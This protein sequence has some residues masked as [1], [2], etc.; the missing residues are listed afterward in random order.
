MHQQ[1]LELGDET[2]TTLASA[3][4]QAR[5]DLDRFR[6]DWH[7]PQLAQAP[8]DVH[9]QAAEQWNVTGTPTILF[10]NGRPFHLEF[11]EAPL[12]VAALEMFRMIES[13]TVSQPYIKQL[14]QTA[15][16]N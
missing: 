9:A 10:P 1:Y 11:S 7:D 2:E 6:A 5:L 14:L 8:H 13:L 16:S 3:A 12:E 15:V 4:Q